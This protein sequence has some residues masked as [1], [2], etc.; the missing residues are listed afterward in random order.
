MCLVR[1]RYGGRVTVGKRSGQPVIHYDLHDYDR[2][3]LVRAMQESVRLHH[4]AGAERIDMLHNQPLHFYPQ[5]DD[6]QAFLPQIAAKDWG[7][8][9]FGLFS[10][11]QMGTCRM[12]GTTDY[13]VQPNGEVRSVRHLFVA[14]A[15]LFPSASGTNPM[16]S[17]QALAYHVA[18]EIKTGL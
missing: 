16:L 7:L 11:H 4:A 17:I 5:K 12:G 15:S 18:Q 10:A 6:L 14:D 8:N 1:D 9:R 2:R 3:H 13:P